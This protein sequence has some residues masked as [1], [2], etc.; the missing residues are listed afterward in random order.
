[1]SYQAVKTVLQKSRQIGTTKL[2]LVCIAEHYNEETG[3]A[4]PGI[5]LLANYCNVSRQSI[6]V[7]ME[8]LT[9]AG[10]LE[11]DYKSGPH[12]TNLYRLPILNEVPQSSQVDSQVSG[13]VK[14]QSSQVD[15]QARFTVKPGLQRQSSQVG[16]TV[17]PGLHEPLG[18]ITEP[19][20]KK[21]ESRANQSVPE[22]NPLTSAL[23]QICHQDFEFTS[24]NPKLKKMLVSTMRLLTRKKVSPAQVADFESWRT[25][26]HWT[27]SS[28]PTL[29]QVGEFWGQYE[30]WVAAGRPAPVET[31]KDKGDGFSNQ[32]EQNAIANRITKRTDVKTKRSYYWDNVLQCE[33]PDPNGDG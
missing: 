11:V 6:Y 29:A 4:W 33:V 14:P 15:S 23:L 17:K 12:G 2:L 10:E 19:L 8:K 18:T 25:A 7:A 3:T 9:E 28:P 1:M 16:T 5:E 13:Y 22:P 21:R 27:R 20:F 24:E 26:H 31:K 32:A 30:S